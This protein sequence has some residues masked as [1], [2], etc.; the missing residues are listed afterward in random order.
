M[1]DGGLVLFHD[2]SSFILNVQFLLGRYVLEAD[3][4]IGPLGTRE[5]DL[6]TAYFVECLLGKI[7]FTDLTLELDELIHLEG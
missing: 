4:I 5:F 2:S 3:H 6:L 7:L 1:A